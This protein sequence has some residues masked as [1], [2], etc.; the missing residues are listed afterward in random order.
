MAENS[1]DYIKKVKNYYEGNDNI[2][3]LQNII[4][5]MIDL[6]KLINKSYYIL[7]E[8]VYRELLCPHALERC[9]PI[10]K[11]KKSATR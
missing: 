2:M 1:H 10:I 3:I 6:I 4:Y 8:Y 5:T 9:M 7:S 11:L